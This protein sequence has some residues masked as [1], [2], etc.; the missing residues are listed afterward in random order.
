MLYSFKIKLLEGKTTP[1]II[2]EVVTKLSF[3]IEET[4]L[5]K[6]VLEKLSLLSWQPGACCTPPR[7]PP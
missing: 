6:A 1:T 5:L 4:P 3:E 7:P 2:G